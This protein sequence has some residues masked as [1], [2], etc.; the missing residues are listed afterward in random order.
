MT[1]D[2]IGPVILA[3]GISLFGFFQWWAKKKYGEK[4]YN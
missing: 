4:K 3:T 2:W 1:I